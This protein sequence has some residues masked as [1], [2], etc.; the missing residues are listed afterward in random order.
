MAG[1]PNIV[2]AT[3]LARICGVSASTVANW[4]RAGCPIENP[5][6][7][8][9][10]V[11]QYDTVKV[12]NWLVNRARQGSE[13]LDLNE[14]RARLAHHQANKTA[15]EE[16]QLRGELIRTV[17]AI[18]VWQ[19]LIGAAR[20]KFLALPTKLAAVLHNAKSYSEAQ[21]GA[22]SVIREA[23][24]ELSGS[25]LPRKTRNALEQGGGRLDAPAPT[26]H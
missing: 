3:E 17:D 18:E 8:R 1:E 13:Q 6:S 23:L 26:K 21:S 5:A 16:Q 4:R 25:G 11:S 2:N 20:A 19:A 14:E 22:E 12:V 10:Q 9:R 15:L 7:A 24:A